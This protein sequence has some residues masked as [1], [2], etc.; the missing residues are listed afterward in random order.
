VVEA[1]D[2]QQAVTKYREPSP[3]IVAVLLDL[4][5]PHLNG[6]EALKEMRRFGGPVHAVLMSGYNVEEAADRFAGQ[7]VAEFI[8]KS[9]QAAE[10][11]EKVYRL[12]TPRSQTWARRF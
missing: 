12:L 4:T 5:M 6:V 2:G 1:A 11:Q 3:E 10:L 7:G 8:Q 9:F